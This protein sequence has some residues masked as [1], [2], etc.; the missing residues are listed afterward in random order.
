MFEYS[1]ALH[2]RAAGEQVLLPKESAIKE[3]L[4]EYAVMRE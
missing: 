2:A 3:M 1:R 4:S